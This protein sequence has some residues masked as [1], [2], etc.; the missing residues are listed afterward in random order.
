M[1]RQLALATAA[2]SLLVAT[3]PAQQT[4]RP[5]PA[6]IVV[7]REF[8]RAIER[9]TRTVTGEPGPRYWQQ[10]A[11]Y[12]IEAFLYPEAKLLE[13]REEIVYL[14]R[15]PDTLRT[16][17]FHLYQNLHAP[18]VVRNEPQE[19]TGGVDLKAVSMEGIPLAPA[20]GPGPGYTVEG[21]ILA[22]Q[23]PRPLLPADSA[24]FYF[25]W[26]FRVPQSG[27]GRMGWSG[28]DL[29]FIAYWYPKVAVY[30]DV[31]GWQR[32]P[33]LG[34]AEF[35]DGFGDYTFSVEA[36]EGWI[37]LATGELENEEEVLPPVLRERLRRAKES[38]SVITVLD[39][40]DSGPGEATLEGPNGRLVWRYRAANVRDV[41][42]S[43]TRASRWDAV[44]TPVGDR[45]GDGTV[46][47][48]L[49]NALYRRQATLWTH[50]ARYGRHAISHHSRFTGLPYPWPHMTAIE[51]AGIIGGGMEFP[52]MTLIGDY[53][54]RT[55]SALYYVTAHELAHMWVPMIVSTDERRYGW[56]D[57]G[58][59]T[60]NENRARSDFYPGSDPD[61][62][63][64]ESYVRAARSGY[65]S[66]LMRWTDY[67]YPGQNGIA[68]Y[69]K[70]ATLLVALRGLLGDTLFERAYHEYF[71][72]WAFK[73]P[74]PWDFFN[75]FDHVTGRNLEWFWRTWYYE[76]WTLDQG[77]SAVRREG[78]ETVIVVEDRG[79]APMPARLAITLENG[80]V[81]RREIP[82]EHWLGGARSAELRVPASPAVVRVEIDPERVFP[83]IDRAN[84]VWRR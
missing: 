45:N 72:R 80:Q 73:H 58:T 33:Y 50:A 82:V 51:G 36:P 11:R 6:P 14:N 67:L 2:A 1:K 42:F 30:D 64:L 63:D 32:D 69:A 61:R 22:I 18:G 44:R 84:N 62:G 71:R 17:Y 66:E 5:I 28:D 76:T 29:F 46:D 40:G 83:D 20:R 48:A 21:T 4:A 49:V 56:M 59:T 74:Y 19:I 12:R 10:Y 3:A 35:Y 75:T 41:A 38:D 47:Y 31:V 16:I 27:A 57:E 25:A 8:H 9:G 52:M 53:R 68:S 7:P 54:G 81:L 60:F 79:W 55:D 23:P 34:Q 78:S 13:G 15:S 43:A 26:S 24:R 39:F 37:V 77:V 70:P 65:E